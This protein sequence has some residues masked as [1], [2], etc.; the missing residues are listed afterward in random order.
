VGTGSIGVASSKFSDAAGNFNLDTYVTGVSGTTYDAANTAGAN[1]VVFQYSTDIVPPTIAIASD[2][3]T[4]ATGQTA[5]MTFTLSEASSDFTWNGTSGDVVVTGGTL[6]ALTQSSANPLV[7]T[8]TFTPAANSSGT[9]TIGVAAG[10]FHDAANNQN[11][12]TYSAGADSVSGHVVE[13]NNLVSMSFNTTPADTIPPT[14]AITRTSGST[15]N[16]TAAES[17]TFTFSEGV[18]TT[19]F[20]STDVDTSGGTISNLQPI[21]S[22]GTASTGY[23]QYTATFTPSITSAGT[24]SLGVASGKFQDAAGNYNQDTYTNPNPLG[25]TYESNNMLSMSYVPPATNATATIDITSISSDLGSSTSDFVT[26]DTTL[27]YAGTVTGWVPNLGDRVLLKLL[28]SSGTSVIA[29][30]FVTPS[31]AGAWSWDY[32]GTTQAAGTYQLYAAVVSSSGTTP[33]NS[34]A[35]TNSNGN[36]TNGGYDQQVIVIDN[37][38]NASVGLGISIST[39][40]SAPAETHHRTS[41]NTS[42]PTNTRP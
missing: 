10:V 6:S 30:Q 33:L 9:A 4:L 25:T 32:T 19:S 1:I 15:G 42:A 37:S 21:L 39:D 12:D 23:T 38:T 17:I 8:A 22:S 34:T 35:P 36:L 24:V 41:S 14:V 18:T 11:L 26:T 31:S 16:I 7:Y 20:T 13:S 27:S 2:K 3:T 29:T 40:A 28:D 5:T